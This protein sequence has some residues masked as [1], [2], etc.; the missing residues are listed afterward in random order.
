VIRLLGEDLVQD[1]GGLFL[2]G[3]SLIGVNRHGIRTPLSG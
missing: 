3:K 2:V 1:L